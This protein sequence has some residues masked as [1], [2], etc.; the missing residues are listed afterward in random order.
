MTSDS[1]NMTSVPTNIG[2]AFAVNLYR[3]ISQFDTG[4]NQLLQECIPVG[5]VPPASVAVSGR[6]P[7]GM[8]A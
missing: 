1:S 5:Y 7:G 6:G 2:T 8:F 3:Y 4:E